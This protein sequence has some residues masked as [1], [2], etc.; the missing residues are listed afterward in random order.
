M[1]PV[2][3]HAN[4]SEW[5]TAYTFTSFLHAL[6]CKI[7]TQYRKILLSFE[8]CAAYQQDVSFLRNINVVF[9]PRNCTSIFQ[10]LDMGENQEFQAPLQKN[11]G[12]EGCGLA[13]PRCEGTKVEL[14]MK[15]LQAVH[16]SAAAWKKV[17]PM[18]IANCFAKC[19]VS[20]ETPYVEEN[21]EIRQ[22]QKLDKK[23]VGFRVHSQVVTRT[24]LHTAF[25]VLNLCAM[26]RTSERQQW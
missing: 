24:L 8:N 20:Y 6:V 18:T 2:E 13:R 14:K 4:N 26:P 12:A 7:G 5:M 15:A 3:Y 23:N 1:L 25:K 17:T 9:F 19:G 10:P 16:Y 21:F 22:L 11:A